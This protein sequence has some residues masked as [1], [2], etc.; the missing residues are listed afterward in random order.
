[1][2]EKRDI[3]K[4]PA[5]TMKEMPRTTDSRLGPLAAKLFI[6]D[7]KNPYYKGNLAIRNLEELN[8]NLATLEHH[9][10]PW[11]ADWLEYLGDAESAKRIREEPAHFRKV[12]HERWS[13]LKKQYP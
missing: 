13:E 5:S 6:A 10:A 12:V 9:E 8:Q 1:M 11:V 2:L 7:G 3:R 4:A